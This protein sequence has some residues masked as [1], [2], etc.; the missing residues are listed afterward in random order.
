[1]IRSHVFREGSYGTLYEYPLPY[2][3]YW[4]FI[5]KGGHSQNFMSEEE[6]LAAFEEYEREKG[7]EED[8][9]REDGD[10]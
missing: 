4:R 6:A 2:G 1:M 10:G 5:R 9:S 8:V 7:G 3:A